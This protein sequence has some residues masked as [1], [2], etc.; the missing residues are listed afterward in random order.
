MGPHVD[1]GLR[2]L[3]IEGTCLENSEG[4]EELEKGFS[5]PEA[6]SPLH[7][8]KTGKKRQKGLPSSGSFLKTNYETS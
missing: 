2:A 7:L 4:A 8:T 6:G 5:H 3:W 1:L